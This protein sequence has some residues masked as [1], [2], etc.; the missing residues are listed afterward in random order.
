MTDYILL[1]GALNYGSNTPGFIYK[2]I[3]L[4]FNSCKLGLGF[5]LLSEIKDGTLVAYD[6]IDIIDFC[7]TLT[8]RVIVIDDYAPNDFTVFL[9]KL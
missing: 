5:N 1:S 8:S 3:E 7:R 4:L 6:P 2:A 9:Y